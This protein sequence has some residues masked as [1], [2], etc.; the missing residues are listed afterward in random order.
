MKTRAWRIEASAS[1]M[2]RQTVDRCL[3]LVVAVHAEPHRQIDVSLRDR[4]SRDVAVTGGAVDVGADVRRVIEADVRRR[5]V[6]VD[7]LPDEVLAALAHRRELAD[8]RP[9]RGDGVV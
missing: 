3:P 2:T 4:S 8:P 5:R 1:E 6:A 7:A 9:V